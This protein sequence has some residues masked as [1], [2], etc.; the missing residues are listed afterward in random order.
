MIRLTV[1][2]IERDDLDAVRDVLKTGFLVQGRQ[3][4]AF[5]EI[6]GRYV[7][8]RHAIAVG[9]CTA[10]LHLSLL[11]L[12]VQPGDMV[13]V[14]AYSYIAT[15]NVI[16]LCGARPVFVDIDPESF[17]IDPACL[18]STLD[19]LMSDG[20][21]ARRVKAILPVHAF[22]L[23][24]DMPAILEIAQKYGLPVVEDAACALGAESQGR[25]A[26]A[27]GAAGCFS[28]HPRKAITTGEGGIIT[29]ND[30]RLAKQLKTLRNHGQDPDAASIDFVTPGFNCRMTEFQAALG[31]TQMSKLER[32]IT[33]RGEL[34]VRYR[35]L[36]A[37]VPVTPPA[38]AGSRHVHQSYVVLLDEAI[39]A[40]RQD[41]IASLRSRGV[42]TTIGT[43]HMPL[44]TYFRSTYGYR[45]GDF[46][47]TDRVFRCSLSLPLYESLTREQQDEVIRNLREVL[48][49]P[50]LSAK[51]R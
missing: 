12:N 33:R 36:L 27:W 6:V 21:S 24:A 3:V 22:G 17:N 7:G 51:P 15:A 39:A 10:A 32:I 29:T 49:G 50:S 2:S 41:I 13:V 46:P 14:T 38:G 1:P 23:I 35:E 25:K 48:T 30:E 47:N 4:S 9:N 18:A 43:W 20:E 45:E 26:G 5:E 11:A 40:R 16:E 19:R 44:T 8:C 28:F 42:E 37:G 34:A 31:L